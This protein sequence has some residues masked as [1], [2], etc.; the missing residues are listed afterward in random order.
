[1][2]IILLSDVKNVGKKGEIKEVADGYG[3]NYLIR[4][5]FAVEATKK[6]LEILDQQKADDLAKEAEKKAEAQAVKE[7]LEK[8]Q[9]VF[10]VEAGVEGKIFGSVSSKQIS[11]VLQREYG[12]EVDKRRI[13]ETENLTRL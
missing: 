8:L 5:G 11:N 13:T 12:I 7:K 6:A 9:L 4:N 3:R 2:K 1:M 10:K